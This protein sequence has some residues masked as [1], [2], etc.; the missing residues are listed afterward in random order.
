MNPGG[1]SLKNKAVLEPGGDSG[2][3]L[4]HGQ[5]DFVVTFLFNTSQ[6]PMTYSISIIAAN[7]LLASGILSL[8][9]YL[10]RD[11]S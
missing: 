11:I 6:P 4:W 7:L 10:R 5:G 2:F 3:P 1:V 8:I 9:A